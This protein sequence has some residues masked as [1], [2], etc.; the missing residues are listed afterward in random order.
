MLERWMAALRNAPMA[1]IAFA[2]GLLVF[3]ATRLLPGA[4]WNAPLS[5]QSVLDQSFAHALR[6]SWSYQVVADVPQTYG[7]HVL[8]R[9]AVALVSLATGDTARAGIWLSLCGVTATL[10]AVYFLCRTIFP[11]RG[12]ALISLLGTGA[13]GTLQYAISPDPSLALGMALVIWGVTCFVSALE[14]DAASLVFLSAFLIGLASYIRLELALLWFLLAL[15][16]LAL[17]CF[18]N[19]ARA[20]GMPLTGMAMGGLLML[21][22][23]LW[24]LVHRNLILTGSTAIL[25]GIDAE[26]ILG[27]PGRGP[28]FNLPGRIALGFRHLIL[29]PIGPGVFAGLLWPLG[30]VLSTLVNRHRSAP[31]LW[32]PLTT[33]MVIS[34]ASV[35]FITGTSSFAECMHIVTPLL[36]PFA[37]FGPVYLL[38]R[39]LQHRP[40]PTGLS[41]RAWLGTALAVF[42]VVQLPHAFH[43]V[44][45]GD[46]SGSDGL[47]SVV[48]AFEQ[49]RENEK[50]APLLSDRPELFLS[51]GHPRVFGLHG[52]TDWQ[53][54][55]AKYANGST[56]PRKM[57]RYL[58]KRKI[59]LVHLADVTS[60]LPEELS[61]QEG[62]PRFER[63]PGFSPPHRVFRVVWP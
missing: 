62:A 11:L 1:W 13:L 38:F 28:R 55:T 61:E 52:E 37:A 63:I 25:P 26:W 22:L 17:T 60:A 7:A 34:L 19:A 20:R 53:A 36:F 21:A 59:Q 2:C 12:F 46:G 29:D 39:W 47:D 23:T 15:Y 35:S 43:Q 58:E 41:R 9:H 40:H 48:E 14:K 50:T 24:P 49:L 54:H 10:G 32:L 30:I 3:T 8:S 57:L 31:F 45:F 33:C 56:H 16:L 27:A 42:L 6:E 4:D 51:A 18:D 44:L 5:P